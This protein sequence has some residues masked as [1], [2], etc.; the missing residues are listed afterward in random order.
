[1]LL[2]S[3]A[4]LALPAAA[5]AAQFCVHT[6]TPCAVPLQNVET[7]EA[8]MSAAQ[9]LPSADTIRIGP[10][11]HTGEFAYAG[12]GAL[13]LEGE[14]IGTTVLVSTSSQTLAGIGGAVTVR[15]LTVRAAD[16]PA[17]VGVN[18]A[19]G[20]LERVRVEGRN[21][22]STRAVLVTGGGTL[23]GVE[24]RLALTAVDAAGNGDGVR[25]VTFKV[26]R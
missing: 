17:A 25:R 21:G 13:T 15:D 20:T 3:G 23:D 4:L 1:L 8:A 22:D 19:G 26:T 12:G 24:Y 18:L 11:V 16:M 5:D 7:V 9:S 10:G 6:T 14:G 2:T